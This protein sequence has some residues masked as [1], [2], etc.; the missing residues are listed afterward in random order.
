[1]TNEERARVFYEEITCQPPSGDE[2][3]FIGILRH[4][5]EATAE[6]EA[7]RDSSACAMLADAMK[8]RDAALAEVERMRAALEEITTLSEARDARN[9]AGE[10]IKAHAGGEGE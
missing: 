2:P 9:L 8:E 5:N 7:A 6:A 3:S 4:L 1:M 10:T